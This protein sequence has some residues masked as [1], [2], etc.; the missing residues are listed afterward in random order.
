MKI[1]LDTNI[2]NNKKFCEWL[3]ESPEKKY[4]PAFAY[5]EYLY[6]NIKKG[7][8]E[9]MVDMFLEQMNVSVIPFRKEE[10]LVAALGAIGRWDFKD[11]ARDYS[12]GATAEKLNGLLITNNTKDFNW[13]KN[14]I[15]PEELLKKNAFSKGH[16]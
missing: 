14:V 2:F 11:N 8:T 5:L 7:N 15:T 1:V 12:I 9:S 16:E 6:H 4:L 10:A 3:L 13:L